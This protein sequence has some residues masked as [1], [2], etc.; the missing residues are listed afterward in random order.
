MRSVF[1]YLYQKYKGIHKR[2]KVFP[3]PNL[4]QTSESSPDGKV[5][6]ISISIN[7]GRGVEA[8]DGVALALASERS[9]DQVT[10]HDW[11]ATVWDCSSM[12]GTG[13]TSPA[14]R[15]FSIRRN[16]TRL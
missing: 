5:R 1:V 11:K 15:Y 4:P 10:V 3:D 8:A 7:L 2:S 16:E 14:S 12:G 9:W 6:F 13:L